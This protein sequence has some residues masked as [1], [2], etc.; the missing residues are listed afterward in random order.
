M[1]AFERSGRNMD[2]AEDEGRVEPEWTRG[3]VR[4]GEEDESEEGEEEERGGADGDDDDA[5]GE[6]KVA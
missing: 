3:V 1:E 2:N 4:R 6:E 5:E